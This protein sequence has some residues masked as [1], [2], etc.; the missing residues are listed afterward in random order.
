MRRP[1]RIEFTGNRNQAFVWG[2]G[3]RGLLEGM[4]GRTPVW[5][6]RRRA[7]VVQEATAVDVLAAAEARGWSVVV[8]GD[9]SP[10]PA[11]PPQPAEVCDLEVPL[12]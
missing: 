9:R 4:R 11:P 1:L 5:S 12:W 7:Y 10:A 8:T 3:A 2:N 6:V